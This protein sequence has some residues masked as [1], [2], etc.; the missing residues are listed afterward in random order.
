MGAG[1]EQ[2]MTFVIYINLDKYDNKPVIYGANTGHELT[3]IVNSTRGFEKPVSF[4][5]K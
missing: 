2:F 4:G 5:L 1:L 3:S